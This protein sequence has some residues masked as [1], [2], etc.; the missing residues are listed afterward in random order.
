MHLYADETGTYAI[1]ST[2][3]QALLELQSDFIAVQNALVRLK[4]TVEVGSL[5]TLRLESLKLVF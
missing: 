3:D 4:L 2:V 1:A 5:Q